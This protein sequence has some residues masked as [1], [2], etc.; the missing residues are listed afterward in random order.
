MK[1]APEK[2]ELS[3]P[4]TDGFPLAATLHTPAGNAK[5][6]IVINSAMGVRRGVYSAFAAH[7]AA[8]GYAVVT[9]DYRGVAGCAARVARNARLTAWGE[10]DFAGVLRWT[11]ETYPEAPIGCVGHS[12]GGQILGLTPEARH[13]AAFLGVAAQSGYWRHWQ[14]RHWPKLLLSWYFL[15]PVLT[16]TLGRVPGAFVGGTDL[17]K[18]A[19]RDWA[20]WCRTPHYMSDDEGRPLR[21]FFDTVRCPALFYAMADDDYAPLSAVRAVAEWYTAAKPT[22]ELLAPRDWGAASLGHFGFFRREAPVALWQKT[23]SWFERQL[24]ARSG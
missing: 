5:G 20:R 14:K 12:L 22:V 4:A 7:L 3:I 11:R 2:Q 10:L 9:Y 19:A 8:A 17:P 18:V 24:A 21:P 16:G 6:A 13:V 1:P 23:A 15:V